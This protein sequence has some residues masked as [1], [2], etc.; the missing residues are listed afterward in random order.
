MSRSFDQSSEDSARIWRN[1]VLPELQRR[2]PGIYT[3]VEGDPHPVCQ[4]LDRQCGIDYLFTDGQVT[5]GVA[6][7]VQVGPKNWRTFTIRQ[8]RQSGAT[9]EAEKLSR[10]FVRDGI[11]PHFTV[12]AYVG[13]NDALLGFARVP[14]HNLI[15]V[16]EVHGYEDETGESQKG[17]ASFW[18][19]PWDCVLRQ[20]Y[21]VIE[22][23]GAIGDFVHGSFVERDPETWP[24]AC[25][26]WCKKNLPTLTLGKKG[27]QEAA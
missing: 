5:Y 20:G 2:C 21:S 24:K 9:T 7:R 13:A 3:R 23:D 8:E 14:T 6:W 19:V 17:Q 15:R 25:H 4:I 26:P 27:Q 16:S 18:V 11:M 22:Y 12:Q 10:A 1:I